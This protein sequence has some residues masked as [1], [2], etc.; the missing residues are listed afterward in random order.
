ILISGSPNRGMRRAPHAPESAGLPAAPTLA[1]PRVR[2]ALIT[3]I[4]ISPIAGGMNREYAP[5][6]APNPLLA[7]VVPPQRV[8]TTAATPTAKNRLE[9]PPDRKSPK[10][11]DITNIAAGNEA[12]TKPAQ[13]RSFSPDVTPTSAEPAIECASAALTLTSTRM[14]A[15][16]AVLEA[17]AAAPQPP[18][19]RSFRALRRAAP[20]HSRLKR[21]GAEVNAAN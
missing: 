16:S 9:M 4:Q 17:V 10:A 8:S 13:V 7:P 3:A 6:G 11:P 12:I 5:S 14:T 2:S 19:P 1:G 20:N 15:A 18:W 21:G